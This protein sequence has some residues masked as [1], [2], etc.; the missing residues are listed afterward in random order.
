[1]YV[2]Y[3][4][5]WF[6]NFADPNCFTSKTPTR[7]VVTGT[8][9]H[10][11]PLHAVAACRHPAVS[12]NVKV[13]SLDVAFVPGY[14]RFPLSDFPRI[15]VSSPHGTVSIVWNDARFHPN[16]D[17]LLQS[18]RLGSLKR[19]QHSPVMLDRAHRGGVTFL[20]GLRVANRSGNLDVA[21][22][23]RA[24]AGTADTS[25]R[26]AIGVNPTTTWTP[27]NMTISSRTSNWLANNSDIVP[28]FGDYMDTVVSATGHWPFVGNTVY[29]AWSDGRTGIPQPFMAHVRA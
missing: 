9:F 6:T 13:T 2:A 12:N 14:N 11:L 28:N 29:I 3:E 27:S 19:V 16:G 10:C 22:F 4:H 21:W 18:F 23:S 8:P 5:N 15:A 24:S 1:V 20:P 17:I 25:V 7:D 26:A